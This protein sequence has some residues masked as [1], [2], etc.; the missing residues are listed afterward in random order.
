MFGNRPIQTPG[1]SP[2]VWGNPIDREV[3]RARRQDP[4]S[5][6]FPLLVGKRRP[7]P[8]QEFVEPGDDVIVDAREDIGQIGFRIET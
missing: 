7:V 8:G 4:G 5:R 1:A 3:T 2:R 6:G